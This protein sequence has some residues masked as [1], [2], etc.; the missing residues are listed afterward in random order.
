M[1][2]IL[3][4]AVIKFMLMASV[5]ASCNVSAID[6]VSVLEAQE[7]EAIKKDLSTIFNLD[8]EEAAKFSSWIRS[9]YVGSEGKV[10]YSHI[11]A[12]IYV[13]STFRESARSHAGAIGPM[14][15]KPFFWKE[16]CGLDVS[17]PKEN[18][19]C[20]AKILGHYAYE[21]CDGDYNCAFQMYNVGPSGYMESENDAAKIRYLNKINLALK[22]I[23]NSVVLNEKG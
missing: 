6:N 18:I 22:M 13:E 15:V 5:V 14:Q 8:R 4:K 9:A 21:Y 17:R 19:E 11:V 2:T 10:N 16:W 23:E 7:I 12:V 1:K 20:G 3:S